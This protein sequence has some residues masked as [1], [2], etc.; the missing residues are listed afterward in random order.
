MNEAPDAF[1]VLRTHDDPDPLHYRG[2]LKILDSGALIIG[3][4]GEPL[5][6]IGPTAWARVEGVQETD[7]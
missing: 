4:E 5:L 6:V 1:R 3:Q 7:S 2:N